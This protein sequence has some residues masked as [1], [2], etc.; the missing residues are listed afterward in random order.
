MKLSLLEQETILLY[1]QAE[2]A[3][4]VYTHDPKLMKKLNCLAGKHPEQ[5]IKKDAQHEIR[6]PLSL[7]R[8]RGGR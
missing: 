5:I 1:N 8:L 7:F 2:P 4:Q 6:P 3:A